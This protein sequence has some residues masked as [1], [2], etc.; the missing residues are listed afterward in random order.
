MRIAVVNWTDRHV[1]GA[2]TYLGQIIPALRQGGHEVF[3]WHEQREPSDR[4]AIAGLPDDRS[5]CASDVGMPVA[6]KMLEAWRPDV[7]FAHG[8]L[9]A[10][11]EQAVVGAAPTV[12]FAHGYYGTC[13]TGSKTVGLP[14]VQP[15]H[16]RF[17]PACLLQFYPRRC[18]GLSP[19]TMARDYTRQ[20]HRL[21]NLRRCNAIVTLSEYM[22]REYLRHG[23]DDERV[24]RLPAIDVAIGAAP[25]VAAA[26]NLDGKS[27]SDRS[28]RPT[29]ISFIGRID[30]L[31]GCRVLLEAVRAFRQTSTRALRVTIAGDGPDLPRCRDAAAKLVN[32]VS[33][34]TVDFLGWVSRQRCDAMLHD[35]DVLA[36]PSLWPE[37]FGLAGLEALARGVPVAAFAV[38]GIP[39]WLE[40]GRTGA[41]APGDPPTAG[42]LALAIQ[43]CLTEPAIR[44]VAREPEGMRA[45]AGAAARHLDALLRVLHTAAGAA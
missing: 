33:D 40:D 28:P 32:D 34:V 42:G 45:D 35:S 15:C 19:V 27:G 8:L 14:V 3:F 13:I 18:G 23:F 6:V 37:P 20:A 1:G 31:K 24:L 38:G 4:V 43:R 2:E 26:S 22:R 11:H 30:R 9:S 36:M 44:R 29:T 10:E 5:C 39:E 21:R 41:L 25:S 7:V 16:R 12:F 17:G